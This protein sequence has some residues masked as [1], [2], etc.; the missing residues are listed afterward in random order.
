MGVIIGLATPKDL[1]LLFPS[2]LSVANPC[3]T[4]DDGN[5]KVPIYPVIIL[6][7]V[8]VGDPKVPFYYY[9][10]PVLR[11]ETACIALLACAAVCLVCRPST[12]GWD[13]LGVTQVIGQ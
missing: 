10:L 2:V 8:K 9:H 1:I 4:V 12:V 3:N 11:P 7:I 6:N 5:P 13:R